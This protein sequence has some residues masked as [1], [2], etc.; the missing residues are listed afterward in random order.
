MYPT[1]NSLFL[2]DDVE[3]CENHY[4]EEYNLDDPSYAVWRKINHPTEVC[5]NSVMSFSLLGYQQKIETQLIQESLNCLV[6]INALSEIL[7]LP[8]LVPRTK[9]KHVA[10]LNSIVVCITDDTVLADWKRKEAEKAKAK[11]EKKAKRT[12]RERQKKFREEKKIER[13]HKKAAREEKKQL[14][15]KFAVSSHKK[16]GSR[17]NNTQEK[18]I[19]V[20]I[21]HSFAYVV[22]FK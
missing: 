8:C 20:V 2:P 1:N 22:E 13:E 11:K 7:V 5:S 12:E 15:K 18:G 9:S 10:A 14:K 21:V 17:K 16:T 4:E 19:N 6:V 3:L